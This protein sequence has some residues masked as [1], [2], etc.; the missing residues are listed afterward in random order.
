[1]RASERKSENRVSTGLSV[2][3][4][5]IPF[6]SEARAERFAPS[7]VYVG[8]NPVRITVREQQQQ[9]SSTAGGRDKALISQTG[10]NEG[11]GEKLLG[12]KSGRWP[13]QLSIPLPLRS[14]SSRSL[15]I[16]PPLPLKPFNSS[17][18]GAS[19]PIN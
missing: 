5:I 8:D 15:A 4:W 14:V 17:H 2:N 16:Q 3:L 11:L 1:M 9:S 13:L 19:R 6:I 7:S 10:V 12:D 18:T